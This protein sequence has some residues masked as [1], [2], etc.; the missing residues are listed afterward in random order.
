MEISKDNGI[1]YLFSFTIEDW[2]IFNYIKNY[3]IFNDNIFNNDYKNL[4]K[5]QF[6]KEIYEMKVKLQNIEKNYNSLSINLDKKIYCL[7][8]YLKR[9]KISM[10]KI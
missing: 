6:Y 2:W 5:F 8:T 7:I 10:K 1:Y 4:V 3:E 9:L